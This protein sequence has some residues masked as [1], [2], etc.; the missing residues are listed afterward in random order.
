M[1]AVSLAENQGGFWPGRGQQE[2]SCSVGRLG[3]APSSSGKNTFSF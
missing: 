1:L 2:D 3:F